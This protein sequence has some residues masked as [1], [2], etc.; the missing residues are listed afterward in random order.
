MLVAYY[1]AQTAR[2]AATWREEELVAS[3]VE[4]LRSMF[5]EMPKLVEAIRTS[6]DQELM[7]SSAEKKIINPPSSKTLFN[8]VVPVFFSSSHNPKN[9]PQKTKP[10][11]PKTPNPKNFCPE[12]PWTL[13]AY[14][15]TAVGTSSAHRKRLGAPVG[16][17]HFAGEATSE[18][19]PST[20]HGACMEGRRA[21]QE[22]AEAL[23][24]AKGPG[25]LART[26]GA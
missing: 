14:S 18:R 17:L 2:H 26:E 20:V 13:G 23:K 7:F 25:F 8:Y 16:R 12:D 9:F 24:T 15:F 3:T 19:F 6:W 5:P 11:N 21:A 22:V 1:V 10:S 4:L